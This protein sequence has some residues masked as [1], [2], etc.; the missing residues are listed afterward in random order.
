VRIAL[1]ALLWAVA[2]AACGARHV[3]PPPPPEA[4]A[5]EW[6]VLDGSDVHMRVARA[7]GGGPV[8]VEA[9]AAGDG[10]RFEVSGVSFDGRRLRAT[11]R[12]PTTGVTTTSDLELVGKDRLEGEV[13]GAYVGR[14][15]WVRVSPGT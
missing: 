3:R 14:E 10:T 1:L 6:S 5:G 4:I 12:Y 7:A 13:T 2:L 11:F 8:S 9:W 15:T